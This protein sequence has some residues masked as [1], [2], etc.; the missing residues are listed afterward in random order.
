MPDRYEP[1]IP[2]GQHLGTSREVDDAVTGHL[3]ADGTNELK[4]HAAWRRVDEPADNY[5]PAYEHVPR[6]ELTPEERELVQQLAVLFVAGV[7]RAVN[8]AAPHVMHWWSEK[9]APTVASA[10]K[11]VTAGRKAKSQVTDATSPLVCP[12]AFVA[13][14]AEV[15]AAAAEPEVSMSRSEWEHRFRAMLA[16]GAFQ[17]EQK[18][19]LLNARI[20]DD[21]ASL[22]A[23]S[24]MEQLTPQQFA[25]RIRLMLEANPSLL[26]EET[27]AELMR[28][29]SIRPMPLGGQGNA[30]LER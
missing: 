7:F 6:R 19:I 8:T 16:A 25:G 9:A 15:E 10:W 5:V 1:I 4:G 14:A 2:E 21:Y 20:E 27:A 17:E 3:F 23:Q 29:F 24:A 11:R 12:T 18:R 22:E 30:E 26:N 28:V 13:S